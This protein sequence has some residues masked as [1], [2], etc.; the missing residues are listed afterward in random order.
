ML[1]FLDPY[2]DGAFSEEHAKWKKSMNNV[3]KTLL[4]TYIPPKHNVVYLD[5]ES[6][7]TSKTL[8]NVECNCYVAN[9][10]ASVVHKLK[11]NHKLTV[12]CGSVDDC[13]TKV[14]RTVPF[15][16]AYFDS[17]SASPENILKIFRA[18]FQRHFNTKIPIVIGYTITGRDTKGRSHLDRI[19]TVLSELHKIVE[20]LQMKQLHVADLSGFGDIKWL[21]DGIFTDFFVFEPLV[22]EQ[23]VQNEIEVLKAQQ[24][25]VEHE[26]LELKQQLERTVQKLETQNKTPA[27]IVPLKQCQSCGTTDTSVATKYCPPCYFKVNAQNAKKRYRTSKIRASKLHSE[28]LTTETLTTEIKTHNEEAPPP[29]HA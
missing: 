11:Q 12:E 29:Y 26:Q 18:F 14:W 16:A 28:T 9:N 22:D 15:Q 6:G 2:R 5:A 24:A 27:H 1:A 13:L 10:N 19:Q 21:H 25:Q 4:N 20:R 23:H 3:F 17:C 8:E 7:E